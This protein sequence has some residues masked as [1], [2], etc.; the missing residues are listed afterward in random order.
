[1]GEIKE[2]LKNARKNQENGLQKEK[3]RASLEEYKKWAFLSFC[4]MA[5]SWYIFLAV[6]PSNLELV[7]LDLCSALTILFAGFFFICVCT[8]IAEKRGKQISPYRVF[9]VVDIVIGTFVVTCAVLDIWLDDGW[10]GG[11]IGVFLLVFVV[12]VVLLLL[13]LDYILYELRK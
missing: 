2:K 7:F 11:L 10:F 12:P 1:M 8:W 3:R 6:N 13:A 5:M 4:L 9:A